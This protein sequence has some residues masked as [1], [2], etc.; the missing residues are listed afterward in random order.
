MNYTYPRKEEMH[1]SITNHMHYYEKITEDEKKVTI[2]MQIT[3]VKNHCN[4]RSGVPR[5]RNDTNSICN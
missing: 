5:K 4:A 2:Y 3:P 1:Y